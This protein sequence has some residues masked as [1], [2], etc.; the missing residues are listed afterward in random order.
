[1]EAIAMLGHML[2]VMPAVAMVTKVTPTD[3]ATSSLRP[4]PK[5]STLNLVSAQQSQSAA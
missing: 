1:L 3:T 5:H 4:N 2:V